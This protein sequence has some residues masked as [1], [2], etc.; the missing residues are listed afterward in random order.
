MELALTPALSPEER[1]NRVRRVC[2]WRGLGGVVGR[3]RGAGSGEFGM[4]DDTSPLIPLPGRGGEGWVR[5]CRQFAWPAFV[6]FWQDSFGDDFGG[7]ELEFEGASD[8]GRRV[9][10]YVREL[11]RKFGF[12][13]F[14]VFGSGRPLNRGQGGLHR[15]GKG[16]GGEKG[17]DGVEVGGEGRGSRAGSAGLVDGCLS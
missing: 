9:H 6:W 14:R 7:P 4:Q 13:A 15:L 3:E 1:E 5:R 10:V 2:N 12:E 11:L 16:R 8:G 17:R